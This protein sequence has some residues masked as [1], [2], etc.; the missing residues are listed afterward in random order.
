MDE[1]SRGGDVGIEAPPGTGT[2]MNLLA[3]STQDVLECI[4]QFLPPNEVACTLR[5][6]CKSF[7]VHL[8]RFTSVRLHQESPNHAFAWRWA[9]PGALRSYTFRQRSQLLCLTAASGSLP[10][11]ILAAE[12][13][14]CIFRAEALG[15]AAAAAKIPS[16]DWMIRQGWP[17]GDALVAAAGAGHIKVCRWL[18]DHGC[19]WDEAAIPAA[20]RGGHPELVNWLLSVR[21]VQG[22]LPDVSGIL[23]AAAEGCSLAELQELYKLLVPLHNHQ[24]QQQRAIYHRAAV[25]VAASSAAVAAPPVDA[26]DAMM[27]ITAAPLTTGE[28]HLLLAGAAGSQ[29]SDWC[30]KFEWLEMQQPGASA[31]HGAGGGGA[32]NHA[33][34]IPQQQRRYYR[35]SIW[36]KAAAC[37][38]ALER[39]AWLRQR[40][41]PLDVPAAAAAATLAGNVTCLKYLLAELLTNDLGSDS[42]GGLEGSRSEGLS[43]DGASLLQPSEWM[44][45]ARTAAKAGHLAVLQALYAIGCLP[46]PG[47]DLVLITAASGGHMHVVMWLM[48]LLGDGSSAGG[49]GGD[50]ALGAAEVVAAEP[51]DYD[52]CRVLNAA[53]RSG[54]VELILWLREKG[55]AWNAATMASAALGGC[56]E[57]I[58]LLASR[59]CLLSDNGRPYLAAACN[60]DLAVL[61][62]LRRLGCPWGPEAAV[63]SHCVAKGFP[64]SALQWLVSEGCPVDWEEAVEMVER[65]VRRPVGYRQEL[66]SWLLA[67]MVDMKMPRCQRRGGCDSQ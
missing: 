26:S 10:N 35:T 39:L 37:P 27:P 47:D 7:A 53:A 59:G 66:M 8:Q 19:P 30:E 28:I 13:T 12:I 48:G 5:L 49:G 2:A 55:C 36:T 57:A 41:Y 56:E 50:A 33:S 62:C 64:L 46:Y 16:C 65:F 15:A 54:N 4:A 21:P 61:R 51:M 18:R 3:L 63:F 58:E 23:S 44:Q 60:G 34:F 9:A 42:G 6:I 29:T 25:A 11:L 31:L 52:D 1:V 38:N 14:G 32:A 17:W 20:A 22:I 45:I 24:R 67:Q 40:G 43:V